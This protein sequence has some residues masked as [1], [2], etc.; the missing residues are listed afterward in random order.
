MFLAKMEPE[1]RVTLT[2]CQ[3]PFPCENSTWEGT[4]IPP[5]Q[6]RKLR[7]W[8]E[9]ELVQD[10]ITNQSEMQTETQLLYSFASW[11]AVLWGRKHLKCGG[12]T[13]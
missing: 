9:R 5:V 12:F 7:H 13:Y 1:Q 10:Q 6:M 3:S 11:A 2:T 4:E 8:K